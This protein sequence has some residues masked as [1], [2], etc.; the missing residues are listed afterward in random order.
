MENITTSELY[1]EY[2]A[3]AGLLV[4]VSK[5]KINEEK[6]HVTDM[7]SSRTFK[8]KIKGLRDIY[9]VKHDVQLED[10]T[11]LSKGSYIYKFWGDKIRTVAVVTDPREMY[12]EITSAGGS[13][14]GTGDSIVNKINK[15]THA[16]KEIYGM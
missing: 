2:R 8:K 7:F 15:I 11:Y 14:G 3:E 10:G 13:I 1:D 6:E 9:E 16:L 4:K 12:V 5:F